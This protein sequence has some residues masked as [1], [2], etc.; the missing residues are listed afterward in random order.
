MEIAAGQIVEFKEG[1]LFAK[2]DYDSPYGGG[3]F[4][5]YVSSEKVLDALAKAIPGTLDDVLLGI[6]KEALKNK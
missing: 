1:K 2:V 5:V 4:E 3:K 6:I